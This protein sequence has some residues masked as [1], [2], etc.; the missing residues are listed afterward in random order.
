MK[1]MLKSLR[2]R[3]L[4]PVVV[5]VLIIVLLMSV[6]FS[7]AYIRMILQ[8]EKE[9][10]AVGFETVSQTVTPLISNSVGEVR[11]ILADDRV[12]SY[13]A[14]RYESA[15]DLIHARIRC[16]E[17][18]SSEIARH[19][20]I[21]GL[22]FMRPDGSFF[23]VLPEGSFFRDDPESLPLSAEMKTRI[24][25]TPFG[26]TAWVG[27]LPAADLYGFDSGAMPEAVMIGAW[28]SVDV[29]YGSC[30]A[31]ML[32][33]ES[34]FDDMFSVLRDGKST[35]RLFSGDRTE[36]WHTGPDETHPDP[37]S[38]LGSSGDGTILHDGNGRSF[39]AFSTTLDSPAWTLVREVPMEDYERIVL[40]VR[41]IVWIGAALLILAALVLYRAWL[42]R[43]MRQF[44][45][46]QN[47]IV[48]MG[49]GDLESVEFEPFTIGEFETMQQEITNTCEALTRQMDTIRRMER[50][51][52]EQ[53]NL[54][55]EQERIERELALARDIQ[56]N[57]LPCDFPA[58]PG[59]TEFSLYAS[60][61]P[62]REVGGDF[63]D[64]FL[65]DSD[66]LALVIADISGKGIPAALFMMV[67]KTLIRDQLL[68]GH[69][70]AA[71]LQRVNSQ[72][73]VRNST[74]MFVTVWLAVVELSTGKGLACNGGH[75]HPALRRADG[76]FELI[77]YKHDPFVGVNRKAEYHNR[78]FELRPG[79]CLFVYTDGVPEATAG[80]KEL[81]GTGRLTASLNACKGCGP[82]EILRKVKS[83][84]D[85]FVGDAE[86]FDDLTM[87]CFEYKGNSEGAAS[88]QT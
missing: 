34:V 43:F 72:L 82:E 40:H 83:D 59:R 42:K 18:L 79:D 1:R 76:D 70:P 67:S 8:R 65:I 7:R 23:G 86:Q 57:A 12:S 47:G 62:A 26:Q 17:Y 24:L 87:M 88:G 80:S 78:E 38:L 74:M 13:A 60:M 71:V 10:N 81:F 64:F 84:V 45:S 77:Q 35:W 6:L 31:L 50:E 52:A 39:C 9:V 16:Q 41:H 61:T 22:L 55:K 30:Y 20:G 56:A 44:R 63:Y 28:K 69:D 25:E 49:Q 53:E 36:I 32:M 14:L 4:F 27:P 21:Y 54:K 33:D 46:L 68:N 48:R 11:T 29:R 51:Q 58:F 37:D 5:I 19:D 75:E 66:H 15:G 3:I 73:N 85:D 2:F